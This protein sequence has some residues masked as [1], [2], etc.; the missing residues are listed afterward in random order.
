M[1]YFLDINLDKYKK[2][3]FNLHLLHPKSF[4]CLMSLLKSTH[5]E[6]SNEKKE[7]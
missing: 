6:P 4:A 2:N 3:N 5:R 1:A 7:I